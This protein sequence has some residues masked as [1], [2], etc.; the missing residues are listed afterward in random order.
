M[1]IARRRGY[2]SRAGRSSG[3]RARRRD[4]QQIFCRTRSRRVALFGDLIRGRHV[5][6]ERLERDGH[7]PGMRDPGAV[8][9]VAGFAFLVGEDA[10]KRRFVRRRVALNTAESAPPCHFAPIQRARRDDDRL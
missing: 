8:V 9:A 3:D 10:G 6:I 2:V 1:C 4:G 5:F 7:E